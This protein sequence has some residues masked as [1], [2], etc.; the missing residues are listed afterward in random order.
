[1]ERICLAIH[2]LLSDLFHV[3]SSRWS[4]LAETH[5]KNIHQSVS[6]FMRA[7]LKHVVQGKG[8]RWEISQLIFDLLDQDARAARI[9]L[10]RLLADEE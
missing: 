4:K 3:Q 9:E 7:A 5:I 2:V 6:Y 10:D 8:V 1:V